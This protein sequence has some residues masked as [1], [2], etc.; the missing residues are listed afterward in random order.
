[1]IN[2]VKTT[3]HVIINT[4]KYQEFVKKRI[5]VE[6]NTRSIVEA[7]AE[8]ER[9]RTLEIVDDF[10]RLR[11]VN[12][13]ITS[14]RVDYL[15][16]KLKI[17]AR[18]KK[19]ILWTGVG[20]L[21]TVAVIGIIFKVSC[22]Q[23]FNPGLKERSSVSNYNDTRTTAD[24]TF[25]SDTNLRGNSDLGIR[26]GSQDT[27]LVTKVDDARVSQLLKAMSE[28][29]LRGFVRSWNKFLKAAIKIVARLKK[30]KCVVVSTN[31]TI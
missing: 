6:S 26:A 8:E 1:M 20:A 14:N 13:E 16:N 31:L 11:E 18:D 19:W 10:D 29:A 15:K 17:A 12:N 27:N 23:F 3:C 25:D 22:G 30:G 2:V 28:A 5:R 9:E 7:A 4:P 24:S 21:G